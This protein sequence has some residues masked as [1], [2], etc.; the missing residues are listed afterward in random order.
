MKLREIIEDLNE[1]IRLVDKWERT[2][3]LNGEDLN[4]MDMAFR[5]EKLS[6]YILGKDGSGYHR[7]KFEKR[8]TGLLFSLQRRLRKKYLGIRGDMIVIGN[9]P[10]RPFMPLENT[11]EF[12][13]IKEFNEKVNEKWIMAVDGGIEWV[14]IWAKEIN[15][16]Y[17]DV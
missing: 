8:G 6:S 10:R 16:R 5:L 1:G 15:E 12:I 4:K 7:S 11:E 2:G 13:S 9:K 14:C 17:N 3:L